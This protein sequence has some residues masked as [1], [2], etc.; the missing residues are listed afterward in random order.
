LVF[1]LS[2]NQKINTRYVASKC[3]NNAWH[4]DGDMVTMKWNFKV[5][6]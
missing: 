4:F 3:D 6:Q 1:E 2:V 5:K